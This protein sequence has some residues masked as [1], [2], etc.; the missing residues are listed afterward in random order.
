[1]G[2]GYVV[3]GDLVEEVDLLLLEHGGRSNGVDGRI[4][5][6]LVEEATILI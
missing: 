4:A 6:S 5:P 3:I 2:E 1:M